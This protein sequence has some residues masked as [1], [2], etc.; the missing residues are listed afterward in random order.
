MNR[1][2]NHQ[3]IFRG[4]FDYEIFL[5]ILRETCK[6]YPFSMH[7]YCL[8]SNHYHLLLE[9]KNDPVWD[10]MRLVD[11]KYTKY[12][13]KRYKRDGAVFRG[14]YNSFPV[15]S[16]NYFLQ[17]S[18]YIC[19]NPVKA[20][21]VD[22]PDEYMWSSY[23]TLCGICDDGLT[24][25]E[26]TLNYFPAGDVRFYMDFVESKVD[27]QEYEDKIMRDIGDWHREKMSS[28]I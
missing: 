16:D 15:K 18:R 8:M 14:R 22:F 2:A 23:G 10:I 12:F 24:E 19:L 13:N 20:E 6:R 11:L 3:K 4:D 28:A 25:R 5:M 21:M 17:C 7:A 9:T 26:R 27:Q 1:G